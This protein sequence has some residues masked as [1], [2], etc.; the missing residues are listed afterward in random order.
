MNKNID[1]STTADVLQDAF[2]DEN[3]QSSMNFDGLDDVV[4]NSSSSFDI[5]EVADILLDNIDEYVFITDS[6]SKNIVYINK[7]LSDAL[8]LKGGFV[9]TCHELLR[10]CDKP[11]EGCN[12]NHSLDGKFYVTSLVS[13]KLKDNYVIKSKNIELYSRT[14]TI[15]VAVSRN[16]DV[17]NEF[18]TLKEGLS[19]N[20]IVGPFTII[21][22]KN[23][24]NP[25]VQ[26]YRFLEC[27]GIETNSQYAA[28]YE[29]KKSTENDL[30][31]SAK[32]NEQR[33]KD[34]DVTRTHLW[35]SQSNHVDNYKVQ[36]PDEI[37][38]KARFEQDVAL[39]DSPLDQAKYFAIPLEV[40]DEY[41]GT[42]FLK[43]PKQESLN[44][45]IPA[46]K[47][48]ASLVSSAL[49]HRIMHSEISMI[50][51]RDTLTELKNRNSLL[52]DM[53][54]LGVTD[55]IGVIYLNVNGL[56]QI[57]SKLGMKTGDTILVRTASLLRQLL[58]ESDYIYRV[59]GDE[60][61]GLYPNITS[62]DFIMVSDMLKAFMTSDKGFSVSV[63]TA[64][65]SNG[66]FIQSALNQA[67]TDM[68][69]E[70]KKYYHEHSTEADFV[71]YRSQNDNVLN[72][73][74]PDKIKGFIDRGCFKVMYQPKFKIQGDV[75][76][77]AG[78]EALVRL[79]IND[80]V[81]PP[82]DFI[83]ALE[84]AH[85]T[86]LIDYYVL[87]TIAKRMHERI[88]NSEKVLPVSCNFS[89]HTIVRPDFKE[90]LKAIMD[91]Y[92]IAYN[93][94]P[95]EVSE[96][97]NTEHHKELVA[98]TEELS[99]EGFSISIDDFGTAHA[100]IYSLADLAVSEVK[101]D[102]KLI[103]N[104][105]KDNNEKITTI[106][107]VLITMCKKL[108]IKTIAEGVEDQEQNEMLKKLGCDEIQGY[109]YSRPVKD[110]EYYG[111]VK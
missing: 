26:L 34:E 76:E 99:K 75:A 83:P 67:E 103:D 64:W 16:Q 9:G 36:V 78:A 73:I 38:K 55:N 87:E 72:I 12:A 52:S 54:T 20:D 28:L 88:D 49:S 41:L 24:K 104:I 33:S 79:V 25:D 62:H 6:V 40:G 37:V 108:G 89:R 97:T 110:E 92:G 13:S 94:I 3:I 101:F 51:N 91:K 66:A 69:A 58:H 10:G 8:G 2:I 60:F 1:D 90:R 44:V 22:T 105:C 109:F 23:L 111:K 21:Y 70:K 96:H 85:F 35:I 48:I 65:A 29:L 80:A 100:N 43:D 31:L 39:Y 18:L 57:N 95:L 59:G 81:I 14:Y 30:H 56:K 102:K 5:S 7:P 42:I 19:V 77:I 86:H 53:N 11:C 15:N 98:V 27:L 46:L 17:N 50:S 4:Y 82:D 47:T 68:L 71:R 93:L 32:E 61:V 84:S 63:G 45:L 107:S 106:L 74:E